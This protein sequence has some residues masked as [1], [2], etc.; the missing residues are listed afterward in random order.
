MDAEQEVDA[1]WFYDKMSCSL[2]GK[3]ESLGMA[4]GWIAPVGIFE[5]PTGFGEECSIESSPVTLLASRVAGAPISWLSGP[6]AGRHS[7]SSTLALQPKGAPNYSRAIGKVR[8]TQIY[9][10]DAVID[11]VADSLR[12]GSRASGGLRDDLIFLPDQELET[13]TKMHI[14]LAL[15]AASALE[16][17]ASTILLI[18]TLLRR[19]HG[20]VERGL[21]SGG[22]ASW[23]IRRTCEAMEASLDQDMRLDMLANIAGCSATHFCRA[24]KR[25]MGM[26]PFQWLAIRRVERAKDLLLTAEMTLAQVALAVGFAAQP[27]FTTAFRRVTGTTPGA[28]RRSFCR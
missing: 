17:E 23:Q 22:L 25:S 6:A 9:L 16:I 5:A 10:N 18:A 3:S 11:R 21:S 8:F 4:E 24:F 13:R 26:A 20:F 15:S 7:T 27:Q 14:S 28:W 19:H 2:G 1:R 12:P